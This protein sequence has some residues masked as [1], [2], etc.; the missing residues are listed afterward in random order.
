ME[1]NS[2][3]KLF[4]FCID[5]QKFA[6]PLSMVERI[7]NIVE[8]YPLHQAPDYISGTINYRGKLLPVINLRKI[9]LL[10]EHDTELSDQLIITQTSK[11]T[12]ALWVDKTE[13]IINTEDIEEISSDHFFIDNEVVKGLFRFKDGRVLISD[14]D[15]FFT[16]DQIEELRQLLQQREEA[17]AN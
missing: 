2:L 4:L 14:P 11:M 9:F 6:L 3:A 16:S 13:E 1:V 15:K 17:G 12:M 8:I 5:E 7:V 10:P